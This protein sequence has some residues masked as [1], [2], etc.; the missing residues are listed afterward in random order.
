MQW[1]LNLDD[2]YKLNIALQN[3]NS[4]E[5]SFSFI[6][7][8]KIKKHFKYYIIFFFS[9]IYFQNAFKINNFFV[10]HHFLYLKYLKQINILYCEGFVKWTLKLNP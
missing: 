3:E 7:K 10:N 2:I 1:F 5:Q 8:E 4:L 9:Y 6:K